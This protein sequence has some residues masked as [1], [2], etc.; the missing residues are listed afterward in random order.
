VAGRTDFTREDLH[1]PDIGQFSV[2]QNYF[3][4]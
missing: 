2:G 4:W 1:F 3:A